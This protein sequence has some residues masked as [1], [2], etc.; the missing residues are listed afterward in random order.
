M[1]PMPPLRRAARALVLAPGPRVLLVQFTFGSLVFWAPPGGGLEGD[2]DEATALRRELAEE[3]GLHDVELGPVVYTHERAYIGR[4]GGQRDVVV[5]VDV[6]AAFRPTP[7]LSPEALRAENVTD[8]RW[9]TLHE[10][11]RLHTLPLDL[12]DVVDALGEPVHLDD[13]V[14]PPVLVWAR[15]PEATPRA[16]ARARG[17][18]WCRS[19]SEAE[20]EL[21]A[22]RSAVLHGVDAR[23]VLALRSRRRA[24]VVQL[25]GAG[26]PHDLPG[27]ALRLD[28]DTD[29]RTALAVVDQVLPPL[30]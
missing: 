5:R 9:F 27:L 12:A 19:A 2:E 8:M 1:A 13:L 4:R 14:V 18:R 30:G 22:G 7:V 10:L 16:V 20:V 17:L 29:V 23:D 6:P 25:H 11:R 24:H 15:G 26:S 28:G 3:V 21:T